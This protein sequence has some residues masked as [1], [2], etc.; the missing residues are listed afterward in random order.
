MPSIPSGQQ[1]VSAI[2]DE[3]A[4]LA[5]MHSL[6]PFFKAYRAQARARAMLI[7]CPILIVGPALACAGLATFVVFSNQLFRQMSLDSKTG[8]TIILCTIIPLC[9]CFSIIRLKP[10][11]FSVMIRILLLNCLRGAN[12]LEICYG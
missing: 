11:L 5:A 6:G 12:Q 2:P 9:L 7:G 3:I 8:Q 1:A 10:W 4:H